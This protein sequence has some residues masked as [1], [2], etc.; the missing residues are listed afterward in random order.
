MEASLAFLPLTSWCAATFL[1]GPWLG[2][3]DPCSK[4][5]KRDGEINPERDV[6]LWGSCSLLEAAIGVWTQ[7]GMSD[8]LLCAL[9]TAHVGCLRRPDLAA[10][11]CG[12]G[13]IPGVTGNCGFPR[14]FT[15]APARNLDF[16]K[17]LDTIQVVKCT[18]HCVQR[19]RFLHVTSLVQIRNIFGTPEISLVPTTR[20]HA[21]YHTRNPEVPTVLMTISIVTFCLFL[22]FYKWTCT[23]WTFF[24]KKYLTVSS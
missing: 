10:K 20:V 23:T 18:N 11:P 3:G 9:S 6:T 19:G 21:L 7:T 15:W 5:K 13:Q 24:E 22:N 8:T 12:F 14:S 2:G 1:K 17:K 16:L 4:G